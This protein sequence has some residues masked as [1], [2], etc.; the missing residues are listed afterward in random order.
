MGIILQHAPKCTVARELSDDAGIYLVEA[1]IPGENPGEVTEYRFER[2]GMY[3]ANQ[4]S[5]T[6]IT[7]VYYDT[8]GVPEG[9]K[10]LADYDEATSGWNIRSL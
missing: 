6:S 7:V 5:K 1:T 8:D 4:F 9:G 2:K 10:T 3:G